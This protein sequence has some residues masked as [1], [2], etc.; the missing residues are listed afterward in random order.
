MNSAANFARSTQ[1]VDRLVLKTMGIDSPKGQMSDGT[2]A[3]LGQRVETTR[4]TLGDAQVYKRTVP[5]ARCYR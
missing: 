2:A 4:S 1:E 5:Q 3:C